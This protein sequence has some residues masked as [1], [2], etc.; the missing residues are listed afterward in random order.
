V[1]PA[2]GVVRVPPDIAIEVVSAAPR[3]ERRDRV[4]KMDDY[5]AFG[6]RFYWLLDPTLGALEIFELGRDGRYVRALAASSGKLD[7]VPGC[8]G[9][10]LDLDHLW[11]ELSRLAPPE[12]P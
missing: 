4:E 6:I 5:A 1:P 7:A 8:P 12:R 9:L 3:D 10:E 11:S 2:R